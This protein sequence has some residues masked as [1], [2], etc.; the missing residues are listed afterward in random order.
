MQTKN[1]G[2]SSQDEFESRVNALP[3]H[4]VHRMRD[5]KDLMGLNRGRRVATFALPSDYIIY[6]P[7]GPILAEVKSTSSTTSFPYA[8][9]EPGQRAAAGF[10]A[11]CGS[12]YFFFIQRMS[13]GAWFQLSGAQFIADIKA[14]KK[15]RKFEELDPCTLM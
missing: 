10:S 11:A 14:G 7:D 13:D 4:R 8:N 12:K 6:C 1:D 9:I 3:Q 2:T 5:K 15:S